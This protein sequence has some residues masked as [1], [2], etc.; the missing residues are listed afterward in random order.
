MKLIC[1]RIKIIRDATTLEVPENFKDEISAWT[2]ESVGQIALDCKLGVIDNTN[3]QGRHFFTLL[4][5]FFELSVDL[6]VKPSLWRQFPSS[7]PKLREALNVLDESL[8]VTDKLVQDAIERIEQ[9]TTDKSHE[10]KSVLEKLLAINRK[11]AVII[12][13]DMLFAGVDT[14]NRS[15]NYSTQLTYPISCISDNQHFFG[16]TASPRPTSR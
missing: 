10:E 8:A 9:S 15:F 5:R 3:P 4:Q 14:V 12:A 16:H 1:S 11:Y 2:L 6:E 7:S 13:L